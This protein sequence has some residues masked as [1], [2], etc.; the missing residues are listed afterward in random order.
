MTETP[1][2]AARRFAEP[3]IRNGFEPVALHTYTDAERKPIYWRIRLKHPDTADKWIRPMKLNGQGYELAEPK[4]TDGKPLYAL[5]RIASNPDAVVWIVEGEQKADALNKLGLVATTSGSSTSADAADWQPLRG[6]TVRIWPDNDDPGKA[7]AGEVA[8]IL[9][10]LGCAVTCIDVDQLALGI[11]DDAMEWLAAHPRAAG[12]DI[13][14][15]PKLSPQPE[16]KTASADVPGATVTLLRGSDTK[17]EPIRWL[18]NGFLARG[19]LHLIAGAPGT[20]KTTI[21]LALAATVTIGG[22]WP[23]GTRAEVGNVLIWSG[24]DDVRDT[25]LPRLLAMGADPA[26]LL[27]VGDVRADGNSRPFDPSRDMSALERE[28]AKIG[29]V[30]LLIV[31]PVVNAVSG[32]SHKN[33]ETRRSL[34]PVVDLA[35]RLDAV[36][37]G[38]SHFSKGTAGRDPV[39]R[40]TGSI[41]FGAL[42]RV[43]FAAAKTTDEDAPSQRLFVRSK[44]NIGPD[45]G[46]FGYDLDQ[47]E[48]SGYPGLIASRVVWG[49]ALEGTARD[50]LAT[51]ETT[52]EP[53]AR[54]ATD[55]AKQFLQAE[56]VEG[57][58]SSKNIQKAADDAGISR[59]TLRLAKSALGVESVKEGMTGG[60]QWRLSPKVIKNA[61]DA[62]Q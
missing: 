42:P 19:K 39:E 5:H 11:G 9:L 58:V 41:A 40:V 15:L 21:T 38:V 10:G 25:L 52:E 44:S 60:W 53:H 3:M 56:L 8:S 45:G 20:G 31:D 17:P 18:W 16:R 54:N 1:K 32:D 43:V 59:A 62:T 26:R 33:T 34:Q 7:Y 37:L 36:A 49:K 47:M 30:R 22:R 51:M 55:E 57:P 6:R 14:A 46:G 2:E 29:D 23:D 13:E 35:S 12:G 24:E 50:L 27:F 28:A 4:F 48:L 61:E